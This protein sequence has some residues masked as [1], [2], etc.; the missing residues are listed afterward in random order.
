MDNALAQ[1]THFQSFWWGRNL[2]Q[3]VPNKF[4]HENMSLRGRFGK[5]E[6]LPIF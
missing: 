4:A 3:N 6:S 1:E 5:M 2:A